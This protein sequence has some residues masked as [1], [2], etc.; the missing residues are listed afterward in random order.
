MRSR[1]TIFIALLVFW[2]L[3]S[4]RWTPYVAILGIASTAVTLFLVARMQ[5]EDPWPAP[6]PAIFYLRVL[7]HYFRL[8]W[9][10]LRSA[11]GVAGIVLSPRGSNTP[12]FFVAPL[13]QTTPLGKLVRANSVTLTPGTVS[14]EM[15]PRGII[16]HSL[17]SA[18]GDQPE[19]RQLDK[20]VKALES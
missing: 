17:D 18:P 20:G 14:A 5:V 7:G 4:M 8:L 1:I 12:A 15:L 16:V 10:M 13:S 6:N 19:Q 9:H 3:L 2:F 11:W